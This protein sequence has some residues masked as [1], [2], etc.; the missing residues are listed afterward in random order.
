MW[1]C[2]VFDGHHCITKGHSHLPVVLVQEFNLPHLQCD[3][4]RGYPCHLAGTK[5][6]DFASTLCVEDRVDF[7]NKVHANVEWE[8]VTNTGITLVKGRQAGFGCCDIHF[9]DVHV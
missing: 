1:V 2:R 4:L 7:Q 6:L 3:Q 5:F 8:H 9:V